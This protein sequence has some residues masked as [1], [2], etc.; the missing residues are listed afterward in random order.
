MR[1]KNKQQATTYSLTP[2][3]S[4]SVNILK[5]LFI[6]GVVFVH[7][8]AGEVNYVGGTL[9]F[10]MPTWLDLTEY[11]VQKVISG[12]AVPAYFAISA[13]L[14]YRKPFTL[15]DNMKKKFR[16]LIIP[17]ILLNT[18]WVAFYYAAQQIEALSIYFV[19]PDNLI[20][21]WKWYNFFDAYIGFIKG[22][23]M[24]YPLWFMRDL[25][26]LNLL[27]KVIKTIIDKIPVI[28][29]VTIT[30]ALMIGLDTRIF[31]LPISSLFFFSA[32][33]YIVKYDLH[34]DD[35]K[36]LRFT[37]VGVIYT[38]GIIA[39]C[40]TRESIFHNAI[41]NLVIVMGIIFFA[42]ITTML[43][44]G[45]TKK[46]LLYLSEYAIA[47]YLFHEFSLTIY[48][49]L[50]AR[51]L[52]STA[53]FQMLQFFGNVFIITTCCIIFGIMLRKFIPK[54]YKLITGNR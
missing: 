35:L 8:V 22:Y 29:G 5:F 4:S 12:S 9:S 43:K 50:V 40:M 41:H 53:K 17:Y 33:Y 27:A 47:V 7:S 23:P 15:K 18:F 2:L 11:I 24:L 1:N 45:R 31:C 52:P 6:I 32:G 20:S 44:E 14:L 38:L 13:L 16:S 49:K 19:Q 37:I 34:F 10:E 54:I 21:N 48:T 26:V 36:R 51:L 28:Y 46:G 25:I 42:K 30:L 3:D 39:D